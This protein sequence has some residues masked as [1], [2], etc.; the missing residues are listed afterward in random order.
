M[1]TLATINLCVLRI[2]IA[3]R[4]KMRLSP[5]GSSAHFI[6]AQRQELLI[7]R[8]SPRKCINPIETEHVID[9][10]S[11]ERM[12]HPADTLPPPLKI[13]L[14]HCAPIVERDTPVLSPFLS[15]LVVFK[16]RFGR[17]TAGPIQS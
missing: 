3:A 15:E 1:L 7:S 5:A 14:P 6:P 8:W 9:T 13:I 11:V 4:S 2:F 10:E 16:V 12:F 17:R